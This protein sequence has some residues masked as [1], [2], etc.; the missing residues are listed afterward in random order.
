[1]PVP[2]TA[3][4]L[5]IFA[6][7]SG[8]LS[9][10]PGRMRGA[11]GI[12]IGDGGNPDLLLAMRRQGNF[13]E[14]VPFLMVMF[15]AMELNGASAMV[16]HGFGIALFVARVCH[17]MGLQK[18]SISSPLRAIGAAGTLLITLGCAGVLAS[19]FLA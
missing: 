8:V 3:L 4:Y 16:L 1:M 2:I 18:D 5:A 19:Q 13:V 15:A 9:S 11:T 7:F 6:V 12:S 17:A 14:Y 10:F